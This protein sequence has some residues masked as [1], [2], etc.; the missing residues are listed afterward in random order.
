MQIDAQAQRPR[1]VALELGVELGAAVDGQRDVPFLW[2]QPVRH[3][4]EQHPRRV[5]DR[6]AL[7]ARCETGSNQYSFPGHGIR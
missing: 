6:A 4:P 2:D 5:A 1:D 7:D 3:P